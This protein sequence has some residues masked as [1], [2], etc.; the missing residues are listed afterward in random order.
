MFIKASISYLLDLKLEESWHFN[1]KPGAMLD[2]NYENNYGSLS[3]LK[4][5]RG[6]VK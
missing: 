4:N 1:I 5:V 6:G 3:E 2:I